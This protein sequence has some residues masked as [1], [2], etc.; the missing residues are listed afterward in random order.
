MK[1][2]DLNI[3][4]ERLQNI[5]NSILFKFSKFLQI[6]NQNKFVKSVWR[7]KFQVKF[8]ISKQNCFQANTNF[9][10]DKLKEAKFWWQVTNSYFYRKLRDKATSKDRFYLQWPY[11]NW[12]RFNGLIIFISYDS[13]RTYADKVSEVFN[14]T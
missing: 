7:L 11:I 6:K 13:A 14:W 8:K 10:V 5:P 1:K 4:L 9:V 2:K 3:L 12:N